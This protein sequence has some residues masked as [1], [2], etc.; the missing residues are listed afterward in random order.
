MPRTLIRIFIAKTNCSPKI[1]HCFDG[2]FVLTFL[3]ALL[4]YV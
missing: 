1:P 2:A 4:D 3:I